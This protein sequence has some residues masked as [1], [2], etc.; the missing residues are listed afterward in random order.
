MPWS[1]WSTR[2]ALSIHAIGPGL[3]QTSGLHTKH[4]IKQVDRLLSNPGFNVWTLFEHWVPYVL[5][6]AR[7]VAVAMDWTDFDAD[8]HTTIALSLITA[9]GRAAPL[10]WMTV[11]K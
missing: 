1:G 5:G 9:H 4:A 7:E 3:A 10:V 8:G 6:G 11:P 2:P